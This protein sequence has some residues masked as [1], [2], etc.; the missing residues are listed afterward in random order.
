MIK[1][2]VAPKGRV[3]AFNSIAP[4]R[5]IYVIHSRP[6]CPIP[7]LCFIVF[8][9]FSCISYPQ[10]L[11]LDCFS[12]VDMLETLWKLVK[13]K[14]VRIANICHFMCVSKYLK[15]FSD[16]CTEDIKRQCFLAV[17]HASENVN[18]QSWLEYLFVWKVKYQQRVPQLIK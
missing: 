5:Q 9:F 3:E 8:Y 12:G 14:P 16:S 4:T 18:I 6:G 1:Y 13:K 15:E 10:N 7:R 11:K 17:K 2:V